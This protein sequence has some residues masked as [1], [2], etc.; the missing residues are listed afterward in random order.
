MLSSGE[1]AVVDPDQGSVS[2]VDPDSLELKARVDVGGEPHALLE[3]SPGRLF[4]TSYRTGELVVIDTAQRKVTARRHEC[5]GTWGMAAPSDGSWV[6]LACEWSG[7]V[8][9]VDPA[10]LDARVLASDL[11]RPRAVTVVGN[12]VIAA[13]FTGGMLTLIHADGSTEKRSL[14]PESAPYRPALTL[15]TADETEALLPLDGQ[16]WVAHELVNNTGNQSAETVAPDYGSVT[17]GHPKINPALSSFDDSLEP[18]TLP[19]TYARFDGGPHVF[20]GPSGLAAL[21]EHHLLVTHVSTRNVAVIDTRATD[22]DRRAIATFSVGAGPSG[23]AVDEKRRVAWVDNAFDYSISRIDLSGKLDAT[24]VVSA[25]LTRVRKLPRVYSTQALDGRKLFYDASNTHVTPA[26]VV[27]CGTCHPG[28]SD[29]GLVWFIHTPTIPLKRR[30]TPDLADARSD[31]AP[32]HWNGQY[33]TMHDLVHDTITD[34][35]AGDALLVDVDTIQPFIDEIVKPPVPPAGDPAAIARGKQLFENKA[36]CAGC[37]SGGEFTDN[38]LHA[39][40]H[41]MSLKPDDHITESNTP[42]LRGTFLHAPYFHD[43]R[44]PDLHDM[45]TRPD[46]AQHGKASS[47]TPAELKDLI[48]YLNSL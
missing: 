11:S 27:S 47:L 46:A 37:H 17:D 1:L 13:G 38:K 41:P 40:L 29:D 7:Q 31:M 18:T 35:M 30:R 9:R 25:P 15:M 43:G 3:V 2:F 12:T 14:V 19:V 21:D 48:A 39:V 16:V 34:L 23:V 20:S 28:G 22:P 5:S 8:L 36:D 45:L 44:S 24:R 33:S 6:A 4:V 32:Y 26:G 42:G 10:T